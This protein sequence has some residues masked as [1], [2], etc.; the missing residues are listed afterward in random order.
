MIFKILLLLQSVSFA[1]IDSTSIRIEQSAESS[2]V[3]SMQGGSYTVT[4]GTGVFQV[5]GGT[6]TIQTLNG[7]GTALPISASSLPLPTNAATSAKQDT[8]NTSLSSIDSKITAVNTG[9]VTI[10]AALPAGSALI[11]S[12]VQYGTATIATPNNNTTPLPIVTFGTTTIQTANGGT[13][14]LPVSLASLPIG[15]N[16]IGTVIM[17]GTQTIATQ[18]NNTTPLPVVNNSTITIQ[19]P[20]GNA[21]PLPVVVFGTTTIKTSQ[22]ATFLALSTATLSA[23]ATPHMTIMNTAGSPVVVKIMRLE[24]TAHY[25]AAIT[26]IPMNVALRMITSITRD[27]KI[28]VSSRAADTNDVLSPSVNISTGGIPVFLVGEP[29]IGFRTLTINPE[30]TATSTEERYLYDYKNAGEKPLTLRAGQGVSVTGP[31]ISALVPA[32]KIGINAIFTTE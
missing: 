22:A 32:G 28:N 13:A 19:S 23:G 24:V 4:P 2:S 14:A 25:D 9:A 15:A 6:V 1:A 30:E 10:S 7:N 3:K 8:G 20:N 29:A 18:N 27:S 21:T 26:G 16:L 11:G 12:A 5:A 31:P 17:T